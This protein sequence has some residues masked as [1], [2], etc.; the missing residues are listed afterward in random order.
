MKYLRRA[1]GNPLQATRVRD[2]VGDDVEHAKK[3]DGGGRDMT[4]KR[5]TSRPSPPSLPRWDEVWQLEGP[6]TSRPFTTELASVGT[7]LPRSKHPPTGA[8]PV[9]RKNRGKPLLLV[10]KHP[11]TGASPVVR[12]G[13]DRREVSG[14]AGLSALVEKLYV[15][16]GFALESGGVGDIVAGSRSRA[17]LA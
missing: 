4:E 7:C 2:V 13:G 10:A 9:V 15:A 6:T 16:V 11:P 3:Y 5:D 8:S 14:L 1:V 12:D 17:G